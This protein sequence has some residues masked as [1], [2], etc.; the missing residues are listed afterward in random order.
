MGSALNQGRLWPAAVFA[1]LIN[2]AGIQCSATRPGNE[3]GGDSGL[4]R[5]E[6]EMTGKI[7]KTD[8]E[9]KETL[10]AEQ[11]RVLRRA[12]TERPFSGK[13]NDRWEE[14]SYDCGACGTPLFTS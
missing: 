4:S 10:T 2:L 7:Q 1:V 9:W 8:K 3:S 13:Y 11:Y 12:G 14:G 5:K 6:M